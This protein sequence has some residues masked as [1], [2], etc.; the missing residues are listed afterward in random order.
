MNLTRILTSFLVGIAAIFG[1]IKNAA[2]EQGFNPEEVVYEYKFGDYATF[3]ARIARPNTIKNITLSLEPENQ[4]ARH[5]DVTIDAD[6]TFSATLDLKANGIVPFSR[7]YFWFEAEL[8]DGSIITSPSYW[9]DYVDNRF[10]WKNSSSNL[11][12]VYWVREDADYGQKMLQ[13]AR[14]GLERATQLIPVVPQ[15]PIE[16]YIYPDDASL[17]SVFSVDT[18]A[19]VNGHSYLSANR[20]L[21]SDAQPSG[22]ITG[23]ERTIPHEIMHLLQYQV[24]G[25][26]YRFAP[27]WLTEGLATQAELYANPE[28]DRELQRA[29]RSGDL[30]PITEL[31]IG[32]SPDSANTILDYAQSSSLVKYIQD[33][34]GIPVFLEM[35]QTATSGVDCQAVV[36]SVLG[37]SLEKLYEDWQSSLVGSPSAW[38][39]S[40]LSTILWIAIP[41]SLVLIGVA[42][43]FVRRRKSNTNKQKAS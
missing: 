17:N 25:E 3:S 2:A 28:H 5:L 31:C 29:L 7:V 19:W 34:Y 6:S 40:Q 23:V 21:L 32:F 42:V 30:S 13:L 14:S 15:L 18:S 35:F 11:F 41:S 37:V 4:P 16:I 26:N 43:I 24:M 27:I 33:T 22:D 36:S 38:I 39:S 9:F 20:I 8:E 10:E 12:T 1:L